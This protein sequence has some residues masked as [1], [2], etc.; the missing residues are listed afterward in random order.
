MRLRELLDGNAGLI[1]K[2]RREGGKEGGL[3]VSI[4]DCRVVLRR[5]SKV[6]G[7]Y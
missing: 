6:I 2:W 5:V 3:G 7:V 4:L 1:L